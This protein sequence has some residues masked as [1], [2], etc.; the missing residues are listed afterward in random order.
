MTD[1]VKRIDS[2]IKKKDRDAAIAIIQEYH[3]D[4][5]PF[6]GKEHLTAQSDTY[7]FHR[8]NLIKARLKEFPARK[9]GDL[10]G[11]DYR[12]D[13][14]ST[15]ATSLDSAR[16]DAERDVQN[17]HRRSEVEEGARA[18][19]AREA[20]AQAEHRGVEAHQRANA[21]RFRA[22]GI[23]SEAVRKARDAATLAVLQQG[24]AR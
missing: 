5:N 24:Q 9:D 4:S 13:A 23:H 22:D 17:M 15:S 14:H 10:P 8:I 16:A 1:S 6:G 20:T 19:A 7:L 11:A 12:E 21:H 2:A 3:G 18:D